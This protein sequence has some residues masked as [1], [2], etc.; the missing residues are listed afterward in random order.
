[1]E[2]NSSRLFK[3]KKISHMVPIQSEYFWVTPTNRE[4]TQN[5]INFISFDTYIIHLYQY[6]SQTQH[7]S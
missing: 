1:M 3:K 7:H 4:P 2:D 5:L 6:I